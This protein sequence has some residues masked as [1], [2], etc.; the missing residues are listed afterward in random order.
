MADDTTTHGEVT[1]VRSRTRPRMRTGA[2]SELLTSDR[3]RLAL[4]RLF[5]HGAP[6]AL[7]DV[8]DEV[9]VRECGC[10]LVDIPAERVLRVYNSLYHTHVPDLVGAGLVEYDQERDVVT[11]AEGAGAVETP[12]RRAE[13][14]ETTV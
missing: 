3:R 9:A 7:A 12:L 13:R 4:D 10:H 11:L 5:E 8:A 14:T 6:M 1:A 2:A